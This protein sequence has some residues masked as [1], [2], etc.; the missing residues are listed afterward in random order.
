MTIKLSD[1]EAGAK[2][3][4]DYASDIVALQ[5]RLATIQAAHIVHGA[6][7]VIVVEGWDAA[8]KGGL[9]QR[10]C[11]EWD[12]RYFEVFPIG[13]P[14][15]EE[16]DRHF[17]WRFWQ[18]LPAKRNIVIFDRS[19]YGRVL[20]ERVEGYASEKD[21]QR[22]YDEINEFEAQLAEHGTTLVKLFVHVT[23]AEQDERLADRLDEPWKRWKTGADDYRNRA[24]RADYLKAYAEMF[25]RTS[26]PLGALAGDRW[27][28]Q[29]SGSGRG[30]NPRRRP[31][32]SACVDGAA[33][34]RY[35]DCR[36]CPARLRLPTQGLTASASGWIA[37]VED[38]P[39]LGRGRQ[40]H[41]PHI[42]HR[43]TEQCACH[44]RIPANPPFAGLRL[45]IAHQ[46][47]RPLSIIVIGNGYGR[48][49]PHPALVGGL[50][51]VGRFWRPSSASPATPAAG[52]SRASACGHK[53]NRHSR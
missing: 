44:R 24:K 8:G 31:A 30:A 34:R 33:A 17:L 4:G 29:E 47:Q 15:Q 37:N 38:F 42:A 6:S 13:A 52:R 51:R 28:Q 43:R 23:Q 48:A 36:S 7:A 3:A 9:I 50:R 22:G 26:T 49:E 1:Y 35:R 16:K 25:A 46:G 27:Q 20:V 32:R 45:V 12:P 18:R 5:D 53:G 40:Y 2:Y 14:T 11:A 39:F 10:I 21:W 19:W 41:P